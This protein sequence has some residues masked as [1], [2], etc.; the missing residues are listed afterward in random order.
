MSSARLSLQQVD[1]PREQRH[2]R[3]GEHREADRVSASVS[4]VR[5]ICSGR[6]AQPGVHHFDAGIAEG[7]GHDLRAAIMT[8]ESR[9]GDHDPQ[10]R[11]ICAARQYRRRRHRAAPRPWDQRSAA[12]LWPRDEQGRWWRLGMDPWAASNGLWTC[13]R[14][15]LDQRTPD[16]VSAGNPG[17]TEA[18][19][20]PRARS[21][22]LE[23][24][25]AGDRARR[26]RGRID[27]DP[28]IHGI[29]D[30]YSVFA[31]LNRALR[32]R[33]FRN[34]ALVDYGRLTGDVRGAA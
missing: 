6:P 8:I 18:K 21:L 12:V 17:R 2:V 10:R 14:G 22:A 1:D 32:R 3:A 15:G 16:H 24:T 30:N 11:G 26:G 7:S 31:V 13:R 25:A 4:A 9:F 20:M 5:M 28:A 29:V 27:A 19:R 23:P 33:G 34:L